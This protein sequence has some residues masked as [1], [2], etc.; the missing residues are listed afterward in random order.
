MRGRRPQ[1]DPYRW[2]SEE[3]S[4]AGSFTRKTTARNASGAELRIKAA[5]L[6]AR[7]TLEDFDWDAQRRALADQF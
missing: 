2:P 5:G 1:S 3:V 4:H 7:K 6:P